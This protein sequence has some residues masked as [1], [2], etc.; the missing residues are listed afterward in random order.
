MNQKFGVSV[1]KLR[2]EDVK[3]EYAQKR[4]QE[5]MDRLDILDKE[6]LE[7]KYGEIK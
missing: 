4:H 2:D 7:E 6:Y 1:D 5:Y 3:K